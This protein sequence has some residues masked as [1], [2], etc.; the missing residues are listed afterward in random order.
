MEN[1][2]EP[3]PDNAPSFG[4]VVLKYL[5][6]W[7]W[8]L[9]SA[10]LCLALAFVY[11]RYNVPMFEAT[12]TVL[13]KDDKN[14][15]SSLRDELSAFEDLG[16]LSA[17]QDLDNEIEILHS[18]SLMKEVIDELD[19]NV[20][21]FTFGRPIMHERYEGT[22]I[23][24]QLITPELPD[25]SQEFK[26]N[27]VPLSDSEYK[28]TNANTGE[29]TQHLFGDT[30]RFEFGYGCFRTTQYFNSSHHNRDFITEI[31]SPEKLA[32][33]FLENLKITPVNKDASV[34]KLVF[35]D[36]LPDRAIAVLNTLISIHNKHAIEDKNQ[37]S[38]NTANFINE[39]IQFIT[40]ELAEVEGEVESFKRENKLT[41]IG[42][43]ADLMVSSGI[44]AEQE[45]LECE[46]EIAL[47]KFLLEE[48]NNRNTIE[49]L[50][51]ANLG[52][53]D[54]SV[55]FMIWEYNKLVLEQN[56]LKATA[57]EKNPSTVALEPELTKLRNSLR[58]SFENTLK[59]LNI[60]L[61]GLTKYARGINSKI[62]D[63]PTFERAFRDIQRQQQIKESLY[64][65]LLQKRE[66]TNIALAVTVANAKTIDSGYSDK[67]K[68]SPKYSIIYGASLL[69]GLLL[70]IV[71]IYLLESLNT[72][73]KSK[74]DLANLTVPYLG[75]IPE[76]KV[77]SSH[78][79]YSNT[80]RSINSEA[81][82]MLRTNIEYLC[83][84]IPDG[85]RVVGVTST[86]GKEGKSFLSI[87]LA[88]SLHFAGKRT[89]LVGTD[90]RHPKLASYLGTE[91]PKGLSYYLAK[92]NAD[93]SEVMIKG[94]NTFHFD[95]IAS[96]PVP[97]NPSEMLM[98]QRFN[99]LLEQLRKTYD[100][101][102]IDTAPI[103][104]VSDAYHI[105]SLV[106]CFVYI[107][108]SKLIRKAQLEVIQALH[109][110][111]RLPRMGVALNRYKALRGYGYGYGYEGEYKA[112]A[113]KKND[114]P[115]S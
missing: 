90:L 101:I 17:N 78:L 111:K 71:L 56:R 55:N 97:P 9:I 18:R 29:A 13:I 58:S 108:N 104:L 66:E 22:P 89:V 12:A 50:L 70:P 114:A 88:E 40:D 1:L 62:Q 25:S 73:V 87:N 76:M 83:A 43:E 38:R 77:Q 7:R 48:M 92:P 85:S 14:G 102:I 79:V 21:Y 94:G 26:W 19:L 86:I 99:E 28:L 20:R 81:F 100:Y 42:S 106:D 69:L 64:L 24:L 51:P 35:K 15:K 41:D 46:N 4:E 61:T 96:G 68:I 63:V 82:R 37:I 74:K 27:L 2:T 53:K 6:Y 54:E 113:Q 23:R 112:P 115:T 80:D 3:R 98:G 91:D 45:M 33:K 84:G 105:S 93:I 49:D 75:E 107:I 110:S 67:K 72:K 95:L 44:N 52:L 11:V 10:T 30:L 34:L 60:K 8:F 109:E 39:R 57:G 32:I 103:G 31:V 16:I 36:G 59:A 65:Y 5:S 47:H